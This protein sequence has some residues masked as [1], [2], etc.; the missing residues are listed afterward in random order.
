MLVQI[1]KWGNSLGLR[2]PRSLADQI[3]VGAGAKVEILADGDRLVV[4]VAKRR[5]TIADMVVNM[6]PESMREAFDWGDDVGRE[7][8]D[9]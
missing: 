4:Q 2:L 1:S 8:V 9:D 5:R 7:R 3:G 6:T